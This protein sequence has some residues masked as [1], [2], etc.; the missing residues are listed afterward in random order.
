MSH[1]FSEDVI[2]QRTALADETIGIL[3][4]TVARL[5]AEPCSPQTGCVREEVTDY[6]Q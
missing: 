1:W 3:T 2:H 5:R 6:G 4:S